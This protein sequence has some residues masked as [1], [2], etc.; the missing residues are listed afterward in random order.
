V[1]T[2]TVRREGICKSTNKTI[3]H[4]ERSLFHFSASIWM[5]FGTKPG[6]YHK[7]RIRVLAVYI[8]ANHS[9][10]VDDLHTVRLITL[11]PTDVQLYNWELSA[12]TPN[13][14]D[15]GIG[16]YYYFTQSVKAARSPESDMEARTRVSAT[17]ERQAKTRGNSR[18]GSSSPKTFKLPTGFLE[19]V[20]YTRER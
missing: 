12:G 1:C 17:Q 4:F 13:Q 11:Q 10:T 14:E 8:F 3:T 15:T 2:D 7:Y 16:N 9:T 20:K 6:I 19:V 18:C 5:W